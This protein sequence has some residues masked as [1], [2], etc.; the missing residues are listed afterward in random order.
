[1]KLL[2]FRLTYHYELRRNAENRWTNKEAKND[3]IC[4]PNPVPS[5][6]LPEEKFGKDFRSILDDNKSTNSRWH[7]AISNEKHRIPI[8]IEVIAKW[9]N[10]RLFAK[11]EKEQ[12]E[13]INQMTN[14]RRK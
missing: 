13:K 9:K 5:A 2:L 12:Q 8:R 3:E 1:M 7:V 6:F 14:A 10:E 11:T 4:F